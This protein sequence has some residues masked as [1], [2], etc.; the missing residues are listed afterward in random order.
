MGSKTAILLEVI[1]NISKYIVVSLV[2]LKFLLWQ[3]HR[4]SLFLLASSGNLPYCQVCTFYCPFRKK[5]CSGKRGAQEK[6]VYSSSWGCRCIHSAAHSSK[7]FKPLSTITWLCQSYCWTGKN[8]NKE[9]SCPMVLIIK[10]NSPLKFQSVFGY[11]EC[12]W[13]IFSLLSFENFWFYIWVA[14]VWYLII[15]HRWLYNTSYPCP[16]I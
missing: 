15:Y 10:P 5:R 16:W 3:Q 9:F 2:P 14:V 12:L 7:R 11:D 4:S 6:E 1:L 8:T 13:E